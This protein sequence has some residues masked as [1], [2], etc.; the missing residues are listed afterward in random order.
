MGMW[1]SSFLFNALIL[2][3]ALIK[4]NVIS[5]EETC[6][7]VHLCTQSPVRH[8]KEEGSSLWMSPEKQYP[9]DFE[10]YET[11]DMEVESR[12]ARV[13]VCV[14]EGRSYVSEAAVCTI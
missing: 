12:R 4:I 14:D 6:N 3:Y 7:N 8:L 5:K 10:P 9:D 11:E 2:N 13:C 1:L